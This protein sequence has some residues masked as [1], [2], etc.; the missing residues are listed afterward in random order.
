MQTRFYHRRELIASA[1]QAA[2][3]LEHYRIEQIGCRYVVL[4]DLRN[5]KD[6]R[7]C[8]RLTREDA[9]EY[10]FNLLPAVESDV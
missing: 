6:R 9:V 1:K 2:D 5:G 8:V 10:L 4:R 7:E 3:T